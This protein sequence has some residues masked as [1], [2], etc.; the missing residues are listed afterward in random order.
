MTNNPNGASLL[1]AAVSSPPRAAESRND[2][3]NVQF[4]VEFLPSVHGRLESVARIPPV[5]P[6]FAA[7]AGLALHRSQAEQP[8]RADGT[9]V[10]GFGGAHQPSP[11]REDR[12]PA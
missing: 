1:L 4:A 5:E 2:G 3:S 9:D 6:V 10:G 11:E 7:S 12:P 8:A